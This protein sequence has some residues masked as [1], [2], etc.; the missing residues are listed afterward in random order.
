M[1]SLDQGV[2]A[3]LKCEVNIRSVYNGQTHDDTRGS[4]PIMS[5]AGIWFGQSIV[6]ELRDISICHRGIKVIEFHSTGSFP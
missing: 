4:L 3:S 5:Q 2:G 1:S 6:A